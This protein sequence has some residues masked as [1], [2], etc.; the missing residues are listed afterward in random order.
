MQNK[1]DDKDMTEVERYTLVTTGVVA[2]CLT[3]IYLLEKG[4]LFTSHNMD[5]LTIQ[6]GLIVIVLNVNR[7]NKVASFLA[8]TVIIF[9]IVKLFL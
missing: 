7:N 3:L 2:V 4:K 9:S 1:N 8:L 5:L 6:C